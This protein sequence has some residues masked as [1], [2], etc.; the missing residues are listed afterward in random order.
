MKNLGDLLEKYKKLISTDRRTAE[1]VIE[2]VKNL[3]DIELKRE[4]LKINSWT[5]FVKAPS[6]V[7]AE[8]FLKRQKILEEVGRRI[9]S[10]SPK[11]II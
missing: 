2:V 6:G 4:Q 9:G 3:T 11:I 7:K 8:I 10:G 1:V 5:V